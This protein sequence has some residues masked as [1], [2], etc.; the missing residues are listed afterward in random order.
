MT[1]EELLRKTFAKDGFV[2]LT[3][4]ELVDVNEERAFVRAAV[5][6]KHCNAHGCVQGGMLYTIADF[7]FAAH[8][9]FLHPVTVTQT[10]S[11]SYI[12]AAVT[13]CVTATAREIV[14]SGH[15]TVEEVILRDDQDRV[16]C[17][18][19]FNGFVKD[20]DRDALKKEYE[21]EKKEK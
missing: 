11:I 17:V 15:N 10:G 4:A 3:G 7:A 8:A 5:E 1:D 6:E 16:V 18:C 19:T 9:N 2:T 14:R 21:G 12:R 13:K 20:A